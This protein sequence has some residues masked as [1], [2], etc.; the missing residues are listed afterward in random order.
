MKYIT[1]IAGF[2]LLF[3]LGLSGQEYKKINDSIVG[4][5]RIQ[6]ATQFAGDYMNTLKSGSAYI[7][8]DEVIGVMQTQ[9]TEQNQKAGYNQ[10]KSNFGDF[11]SLAY[12]ETWVQTKNSDYQIIRLKGIFDKNDKMEIRVIL[13]SFNKIAGFWV[14][15]WTENIP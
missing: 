11:V 10:L 13:N 7:F 1:S 8:K 9:L 3:C 12:A 5:K 4:S 14:K 2:C 15:P 6:I